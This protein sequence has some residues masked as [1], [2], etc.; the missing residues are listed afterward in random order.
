MVWPKWFSFG[1]KTAVGQSV[2]LKSWENTKS[3]DLH[4]TFMNVFETRNICYLQPMRKFDSITYIS[5]INGF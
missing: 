2:M 1:V 3:R 4:S 5:S